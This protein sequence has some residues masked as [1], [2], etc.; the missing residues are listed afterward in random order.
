MWRNILEHHLAFWKCRKERIQKAFIP[1]LSG[2][3]YPGVIQLSI[4]HLA[5]WLSCER[6]RGGRQ[7]EKNKGSRTTVPRTARASRTLPS[8][9]AMGL[10]RL[11]LVD[12]SSSQT[13]ADKGSQRFHSPPEGSK[14]YSHSSP[15]QTANTISK[16][17]HSSSKKKAQRRWR[18]VA[19]SGKIW[20]DEAWL[21][22]RAPKTVTKLPLL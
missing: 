1:S 22:L 9:E 13:Q 14:D 16:A 17:W 18:R 12:A 11:K 19:Y 3:P 7:S 5:G 10:Q 6:L 8:Y 20:Q 15:M 2:A 4:P 21:S